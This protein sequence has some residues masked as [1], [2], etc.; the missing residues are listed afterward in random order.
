MEL[1]PGTKPTRPRPEQ[2]GLTAERARKLEYPGLS[3]RWLSIPG[4][5]FGGAV[6]LLVYQTTSNGGAT[7]I[8][9]LAGYA[10]PAIVLFPALEAVWERTQ[11]KWWCS[12]PPRKFEEELAMLLR[13]RGFDV[14]WTGRVGDGGVDIRLDD[15]GKVILI[16]C[17]AHQK[18][19]G[20]ATVRDVFGTMGH[21]RADET[22][23]VSLA[24][25]TKGA[26]KFCAGKPIR[27]LTIA[28]ILREN[29]QAAERAHG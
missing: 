26:Q 1:W 10:L 4:V 28:E 29:P 21:F 19:V 8:G 13:R 22:W 14:N 25:F 17:K 6:A 24:G 15:R 11:V 16:Q 5:V 12:L 23:V 9:F 18:P 3:E 7:F 20:P 27:L 2:F